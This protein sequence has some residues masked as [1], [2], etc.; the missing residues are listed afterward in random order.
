[1]AVALISCAPR[2][3]PLAGVPYPERLPASA[4]EPGHSR[5]VFR[6]EYGDPIFSARG[7][8]V[9]RLASPDSVRLDFFSD[10]NLGGGF[11][12]LIGDSLATPSSDDARRY[13]PPVPLLWA[14]MGVLRVVAADTT[15]RLDGDMLRADIGDEPRWRAAFDAA[16]LVSLERIEGNRLRESVRRDSSTISYRNYG[17]RRRL[18]LTVLRRLSDPAYDEAIWRR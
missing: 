6:W 12:I 5:L 15:A 18:T 1:M 7:E 17:S 8:G 4:L 3:R 16:S 10:G 13:L 14:A 9:A 2:T 11:A